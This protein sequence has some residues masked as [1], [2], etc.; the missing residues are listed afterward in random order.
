MCK[1]FL[2]VHNNGADSIKG[3]ITSVKNFERNQILLLN[4]YHPR[5]ALYIMQSKAVIATYGGLLSHIA[6]LCRE[7]DIPCI[8]I[9][10]RVKEG[11]Y[12]KIDFIKKRF[13]TI[14]D[15]TNS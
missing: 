5:Y 10:K 4:D 6:I 1:D 11:D 13:C 12:V 2:V 7:M 14:N 8:K 3:K 15:S 9:R